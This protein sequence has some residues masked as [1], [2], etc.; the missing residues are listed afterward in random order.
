MRK[1][2]DPVPNGEVV[3]RFAVPTPQVPKHE[4]DEAFFLDFYGLDL[5]PYNLTT[6][7]KK[8]QPSRL[9]V[10][11]ES[12]VEPRRAWELAGTKAKYQLILRLNV[13]VI[14][15]L[16]PGPPGT[17]E[18]SLDVVWYTLW[19]EHNGVRVP[20]SRPGTEAHAGISNLETGTK[21]QRKSLRAQLAEN[22]SVNWLPLE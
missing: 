1:D 15:S 3:V 4:P 9:S 18:F 20:D 17:K 14:R 5:T 12:L 13:D 7:D 11:A 21:L 10:W 2:W 6:E 8:E 16:K 19:I 22:S